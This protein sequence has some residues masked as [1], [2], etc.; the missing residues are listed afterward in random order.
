MKLQLCGTAVLALLWITAC[1][2]TVRMEAPE[3]PIEINMN[4][5]IKHEVLVKVEKDIDMMLEENDELF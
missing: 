4:I 2:P 3:K 5:N 1:S